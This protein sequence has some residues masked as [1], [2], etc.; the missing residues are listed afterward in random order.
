VE[1]VKTEVTCA[2]LSSLTCLCRT[3]TAADSQ[4][5]TSDMGLGS[6]C[7]QELRSKL[8][9]VVDPQWLVHAYSTYKQKA[10]FQW[11]RP[12][13]RS[14]RMGMG[15]LATTGVTQVPCHLPPPAHEAHN[16]LSADAV[17]PR[18]GIVAF[19]R[20]ACNHVPSPAHDHCRHQNKVP[21]AGPTRSI[22]GSSW[23]NSRAL[24]SLPQLAFTSGGSRPHHQASTRPLSWYEQKN[25]AHTCCVLAKCQQ[26]TLG[27]F[28]ERDT[29]RRQVNRILSVSCASRPGSLSYPEHPF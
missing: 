24:I 17:P 12:Q 13:S 4:W 21:R 16:H 2:A 6:G 5:I 3:R 20:S 22:E 25:K 18:L 15:G 29:G 1:G 10:T 9:H 26:Q 7:E 23:L 27:P 14:I 28:C 19:A 11:L 8:V